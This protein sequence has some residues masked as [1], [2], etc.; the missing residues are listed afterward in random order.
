MRSD[1]PVTS[2]RPMPSQPP[3][4]SIMIASSSSKKMAT[5]CLRSTFEQTALTPPDS[6]VLASPLCRRRVSPWAL[7]SIA[8]WPLSRLIAITLTRPLGRGG[9]A[10]PV[11]REVWAVR[12]DW[13]RGYAAAAPSTGAPS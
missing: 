9:E 2:I 12:R 11:W 8:A 1:W 6:I 5:A 10:P 4:I 3:M 13:L 7:A